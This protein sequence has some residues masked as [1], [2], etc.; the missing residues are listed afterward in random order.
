[1][2]TKKKAKKA[3]ELFRNLVFPVPILPENAGKSVSQ[4]KK[5]AESVFKREVYPNLEN[6]ELWNITNLK[7]EGPI[8]PQMKKYIL[9][10][11]LKR[12]RKSAPPG[13]TTVATPTTPPPSA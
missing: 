12:N 6:H 9:T 3:N 7:W 10:A 1:M 13:D 4:R 5:N 8:K 2:A 11:R